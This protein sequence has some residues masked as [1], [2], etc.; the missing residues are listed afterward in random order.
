MSRAAAF[1]DLDKTIIDADAGVL[2]GSH[3]LRLAK[4]EVESTERKERRR[5]ELRYRMFF[6][7]VVAKAAY[8][9]ILYALR[10]MKRSHVVRTAYTFFKGMRREHL[11][12]ALDGF[13]D[14]GLRRRVY[15]VVHDV[16]ERHRKAGHH[17]VLVTT[18][19]R[20]IAERFAAMLGIDEVVACE[21]EEEDGILTGRVRGPL[22]GEDKAR[23]AERLAAERGWDLAAS[24][25]YTDHYS[26]LHLL[27]KVG[28]PR[29]VH[30]NKR[31]AKLAEKRG[32]P[33]L[34]FSDPDHAF[35]PS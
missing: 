22:Y 20:P 21:L 23:A 7:E 27:E 16:L 14:D 31:L 32:W 9:R 18:G 30:P 25:A 28:H 11:E 33:V 2:F 26:D 6:A 15:P 1:F 4:A 12:A 5:R 34:D 8:T 3:L 29:A 24:F 35:A 10:I 17:T 13:F 19:M